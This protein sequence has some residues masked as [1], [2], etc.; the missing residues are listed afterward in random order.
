MTLP[1]ITPTRIL[2]ALAILAI[3]FL[4]SDCHGRNKELEAV[5]ANLRVADSLTSAAQALSMSESGKKWEY[6]ESLRL[7]RFERDSLQRIVNMSKRTARPAIA[8][9]R[10]APA[11]VIDTACCDSAKVLADAYESLAAADSLKDLN[12]T[13][14]LDLAGTRIEDLSSQVTQWQGLW[15]VSDSLNRSALKI[16]KPRAKV[17]FG[18]GGGAAPGFYQGGVSLGLLTRKNVLLLGHAGLSNVGM[19]YEGKWLKTISL[20]KRR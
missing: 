16:A 8:V 15:R 11:G 10:A 5:R 13:Q 12:Y 3:I 4:L 14:Q 17:L 19:Y 2:L 20:R 18:V 1:K 6:A 9:I 7:A